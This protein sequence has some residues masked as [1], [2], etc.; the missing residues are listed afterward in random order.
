MNTIAMTATRSRERVGAVGQRIVYRLSEPVKTD[1][2]PNL[3]E[4]VALSLGRAGD[5]CV[6]PSDEEGNLLDLVGFGFV[7]GVSRWLFDEEADAFVAA[8]IAQH[9]ADGGAG[10][11]FAPA[12]WEADA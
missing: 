2:C 10:L 8:C 3:F 11:K 9:L 7:M 4:Y 1:A 5:T 6:F 12:G